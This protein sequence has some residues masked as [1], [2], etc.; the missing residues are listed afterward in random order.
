[1]V[2]SRE[3]AKELYSPT[4][5]P[6][7]RRIMCANTQA[8]AIIIILQTTYELNLNDKYDCN[9]ATYL[10]EAGRRVWHQVCVV[11]LTKWL[12]QCAVGAIYNAPTTANGLNLNPEA[13][14]EDQLNYQLN[15]FIDST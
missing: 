5:A 14:D 4:Y 13:S 8:R 2:L 12:M 1:M 6:L 9:L 11:L 7:G 10:A 15:W 3:V